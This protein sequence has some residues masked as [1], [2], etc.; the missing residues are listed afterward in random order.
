VGRATFKKGSIPRAVDMPPHSPYA[1]RPSTFRA[2]RWGAPMLPSSCCC[3]RSATPRG[4][5]LFSHRSASRIFIRQPGC[6]PPLTVTQDDDCRPRGGEKRAVPWPPP[7]P[8]LQ[9]CSSS[10]LGRRVHRAG[11]SLGVGSDPLLPSVIGGEGHPPAL[12]R[13]RPP[14]MRGKANCCCL[15]RV[16]LSV[17]HPNGGR[18]VRRRL[19]SP[20]L[21]RRPPLVRLPIAAVV[22]SADETVSATCAPGLRVTLRVHKQPGMLLNYTSDV[23]I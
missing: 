20:V 5:A 9:G 15:A 21:K 22:A 1:L 11:V 23:H 16:Q 18:V 14:T 3:W 12:R 2:P 4:L 8:Q 10:V 13:R 19:L 6:S 7:Y 17:L